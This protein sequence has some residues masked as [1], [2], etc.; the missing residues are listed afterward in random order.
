[1]I[2]SLNGHKPAGKI[3]GLDDS[4]GITHRNLGWVY[5]RIENDIPKAIEAY[6][7]ALAS[8]QVTP[9]LFIELDSLYEKG[10]IVPERR[11]A[12]LE[13][14][15]DILTQR[16]ESFTREI[17]VLVLMGKYDQ[18]IDYLTNNYFH[19]QEGDDSIHDVY[20]DAHLLKGLQ[21]IEEEKYE[22]ALQHFQKASEYP[23]NLSVG[24][25]ERDPRA[26][27]V[28]WYI[29]SAYEALGQTD[30][31]QEIYQSVPLE[32]GRFGGSESL[33]YQG[34]ILTKTDRLDEAG[35]T[36]DRLIESGRRRLSDSQRLISLPNSAS[37]DSADA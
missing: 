12:A 8:G 31:A 20:M 27:Q 14:H 37:A 35:K 19:V 21:C 25:P 30:K 32:R 33:F 3:G 6:E 18:A 1:M 34:L 13:R 9:R 5:S 15:H 22:Q 4:F 17:R 11:Y 23:E 26:P 36:F 16:V 7:K 2:Y 24:R 10:N 28:A 29:A